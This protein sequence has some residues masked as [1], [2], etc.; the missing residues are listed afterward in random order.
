VNTPELV[1]TVSAV[2]DAV[3]AARR[4]GQ[5]IRLVP[6]MGALHA[7]HTSLIGRARADGGFVAVSIFVNPL[8]FGPSE[9]FAAY[10]RDLEGDV[11]A[12]ARAGGDL[13]FAPSVEEMYEAIPSLTRVSVAEITEPLCGAARPGHFDGVA[14]VVAKLFAIF[15]A[16]TAYFGQ[17]D[18]Q[19]LAVVRRMAQDLSFRTAV[20]ACPTIREADGLAM[21]SRNAYLTAQE[22]AAAP[23]L[24]RALRAAAD[25]VHAGEREPAALRVKLMEV[26]SSEP[27]LDVEYAEVRDAGTIE[28][29]GTIDGDVLVAVAARLGRARLIDNIVL[30][31]HGDDVDVEAGEIKGDL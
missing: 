19:Q 16:D 2:R 24:Y 5:A 7:G 8:Q 6:T 29:I 10:P 23:T 12:V 22:R 15:E 13:I 20:V 21:S 30:H 31:V 25:L 14:T 9:D 18:A 27:R 4:R 11:A 17:K 28:R 26:L 1:H 3:A